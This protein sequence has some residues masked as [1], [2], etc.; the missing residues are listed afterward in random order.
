MRFLSGQRVVH[1]DRP[2]W[3]V[4]VV[5]SAM[6][7]GAVDRLRIRFE[8]A[9]LKTL[10]SPPAA[11]RAAADPDAADDSAP[12]DRLAGLDA[13]EAARVMASLPEPTRD[14]FTR[15]PDRL[16]A[17]LALYRFTGRGGSLI[18]W[19]SAQSGLADPL[20]RYT[21]HELE[22]LFERFAAARED[23]LKSLAAEARRSPPA[24][25][26]SVLRDAPP[27]G[28]QAWLRAIGR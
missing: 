6:R 17:T 4:G 27:A 14:P 16:A 18:D 25:L 22:T 2:E 7:A 20:S 12:A 24:H 28:R 19:A 21:R 13:A 11:I 9:G 15:I 3:G 23:H 26:E 5:L 8:R 10:A 1:A